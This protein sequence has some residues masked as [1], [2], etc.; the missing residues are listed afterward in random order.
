MTTY[1]FKRNI[2]SDLILS[3]VNNP[4]TFLLGPKRCGKT[5]SLKQLDAQ[6]S[7][8]EYINFTAL[9][10]DQKLDAYD[11]ICS[12]I[13]QDENKTYL[14][15]EI[16]HSFMPELEIKEISELFFETANTHT[17]LVIT[18]NPSFVLEIWAYRA[19]GGNTAFIR[20]DYLTYD[21]WL[22]YRYFKNEG[23]GYPTYAK[24]L[25]EVAVFHHLTS[26]KDH[27]ASCIS[28][29]CIS[30]RNTT[31]V[32]WGNDVY[33]IEEDIDSLLDICYLSL[34]SI[35]DTLSFPN[36]NTKQPSGIRQIL[37][38]FA[39][40]CKGLGKP[41]LEEKLV[42]AFAEHYDHFRK[43]DPALLKQGIRFL[44]LNGI[45]SV[46]TAPED[47]DTLIDIL[48]DLKTCD[49]KRNYNND[50]FARYHFYFR[51]SL[52]YVLVLKDLWGDQYPGELP[53]ALAEC[54][55][56]I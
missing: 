46:I 27:L 53:Q 34:F 47:P 12:S 51:H 52:F 4:I 42:N 56:N 5:V 29:A 30:N 15:D 18:G 40:A 1:P 11:E 19:F 54:I 31:N 9:S 49:P 13:R 36:I 2:C 44:Y 16:T 22:K 20:T 24:F 45:L 32:V 26:L 6:F 38:H 17:H 37:H 55:R 48:R 43:T 35:T 25:V 39:R 7:N 28:D 8:A 10:D 50:L 21:E 14:L 3:S 33:R 41:V 23:D